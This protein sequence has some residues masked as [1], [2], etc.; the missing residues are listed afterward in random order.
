MLIGIAPGLCGTV[1]VLDHAG[2][3]V[4]LDDTPVLTLRTKSRLSDGV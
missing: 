4:V 2:V 3:L 1:A